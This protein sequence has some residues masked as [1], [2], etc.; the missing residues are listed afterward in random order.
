MASDV[1]RKLHEDSQRP[2][3]A[4]KRLPRGPT[5]ALVGSDNIIKISIS[6]L[7]HAPFQYTLASGNLRKLN[8]AKD[9]LRKLPR[10]LLEAARGPQGPE[11]ARVG[12]LGRLDV[13]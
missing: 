10:G 3:E 4:P 7:R 12:P 5:R 2:Q 9:V 11:E 6:S 13:Y 8:M 1:L